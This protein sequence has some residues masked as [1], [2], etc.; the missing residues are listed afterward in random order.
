MEE[1]LDKIQNRLEEAMVDTQLPRIY[2]N[3]FINSVGAADILVILERNG[4]HVAILNFSYTTAKTFVQ[5]LGQLVAKLE[6]DMGQPV[7]TI[8]EIQAMLKKDV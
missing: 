1:A 6:Q 2:F 7:K 8:D 3:G 4:Q 5:K